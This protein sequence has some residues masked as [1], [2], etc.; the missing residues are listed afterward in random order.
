MLPLYAAEGKSPKFLPIE[1]EKK[2]GVEKY[3]VQIE[4]GAGNVVLDRVVKENRIQFILPPG[5]YRIRIGAINTFDK[6]D[7]WG[8]WQNFEIRQ[9]K[10]KSGFFKTSFP[11]AG[12]LISGGMSYSMFL[13]PWRSLYKDG[14]QSYMG[15]ISYHFGSIKLGEKVKFLQYTGFELEVN[16]ALFQGKNDNIFNSSLKLIIGGVNIFFKTNFKFPINL[17]AKLGGGITYSQQEYE[18]LLSLTL[19]YYSGSLESMDPY[20]KVGGAIELNFLYVMSLQ[21]GIDNYFIF[22]QDE[23]NMSMRFYAL[24]GFRI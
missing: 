23:M 21:L 3:Q 2:E 19:P 16:Y 14:Y 11:K 22:Y 4:A 15:N 8:D 18:R 7:F 12:L 5:K 9:K 24:I 6:I 13:G 20:M 10:G 17:Y 1:W